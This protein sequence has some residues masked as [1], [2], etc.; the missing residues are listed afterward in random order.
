MDDSAEEDAEPEPADWYIDPNYLPHNRSASR[1]QQVIPPR[2]LP[3]NLPAHLRTFATQ[4][5]ESP[6]F[7]D[8]NC[9][10][11]RAVTTDGSAYCDWT[12]ILT[13]RDGRERQI[14]G[15]AATVQQEVRAH[16]ECVARMLTESY[17]LF[18]ALETIGARQDVLMEGLDTDSP[19]WARTLDRFD[20]FAVLTGRLSGGRRKRH[21][22]S[23]KQFI[24]HPASS[25]RLNSL[26]MTKAARGI[27]Q[28]DRFHGSASGVET[29]E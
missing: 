19:R 5:I 26:R 15:A 4:L 3:D 29:S 20:V 22:P 6:F 12:F 1:P 21:V 27:W 9:I 25:L 8:V 24:S 17:K 28:L 16:I 7:E 18:E 11:A 13:L 2:T 14:R 23:V 10:D